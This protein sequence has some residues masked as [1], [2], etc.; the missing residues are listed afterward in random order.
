MGYWQHIIS[1]ATAAY[2]ATILCNKSYFEDKVGLV[3]MK[4]SFS[5]VVKF[6]NFNQTSPL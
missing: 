6:F 2:Q 5:F 4:S 3:A 1:I